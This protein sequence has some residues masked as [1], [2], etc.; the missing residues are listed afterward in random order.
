MKNLIYSVAR[1]VCCVA[2]VS[3]LV[4]LLRLVFV[5]GLTRSEQS[6]HLLV[7]VAGLCA[8]AYVILMQ[9]RQWNKPVREMATLLPLARAGEAPIDDLLKIRGPL[10]ELAQNVHCILRDLRQQQSMV[11]RLELEIHQ[12]V[13]KKTDSL[14][15]TI[16]SLRNQA[17]RDAITGLFNRRMLDSV[18]PEF[19]DRTR[20]GGSFLSLLMIDID[21][22]KEVNDT[23]GHAAGDQ[24]LITVA[25]IIRSGIRD[26]DLAFRYGGDEFVLILPELNR[27]Q[28]LAMAHRLASMVDE[29]GKTLHLDYPPALSIGLACSDD[30]PSS[31]ADQLLRHADAELYKIK[32]AHHPGHH[33]GAA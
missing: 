19:V 10:E 1:I 26:N 30:L 12:R 3:C 9:H 23:L 25:Q 15:R 13:A 18:L 28:S 7:V 16:G 8:S 17:T 33:R 5:S 11:A 2:A 21:Y 6:I 20:A 32:M 24:L 4:L 31:T 29:Y 27:P 14:Q 22:F